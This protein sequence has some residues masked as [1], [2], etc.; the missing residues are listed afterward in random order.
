MLESQIAQLAAAIPSN[1]KGK[2][3]GQLEEIETTNLVEI[4]NARFYKEPSTSGWRDESMPIKKGNPRRHVI[5]IWIGPHE[6]REVVCDLGASV[7]IMP[8]VIYE[9]IHGGLLLYTAMHLQ[10]ADQSLC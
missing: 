6:F 5:P 8:K 7:N 2:I 4:H 10:L 3:P 9:K 1:E